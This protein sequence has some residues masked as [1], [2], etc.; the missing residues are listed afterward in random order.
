MKKEWTK[1]EARRDY[2]KRRMRRCSNCKFATC[3]EWCEIKATIPMFNGAI[4]AYF[5][6]YYTREEI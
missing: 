1:E 2:A 4:G 3:H 5:C 6:K